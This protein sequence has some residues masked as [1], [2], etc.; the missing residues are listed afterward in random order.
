MRWVSRNREYAEGWRGKR[1]TYRCLV[2]G[3]EFVVDTLNPS[4][5]A[6]R[7]CQECKKMEVLCSVSACG[8]KCQ[9]A[10]PHTPIE[11]GDGDCREAHWCPTYKGWVRCEEV[12]K[13]RIADRR[14]ELVSA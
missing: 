2:C 5:K 1:R 7:I 6:E 3:E 4:K 8:N 10:E 13:E 11:S 9:H 12:V 14:L